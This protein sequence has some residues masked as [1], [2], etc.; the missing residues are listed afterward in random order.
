MV[1]WVCGHNYR[2]PVHKSSVGFGWEVG[3][4]I[5]PNRR[6]VGVLLVLG[7][8]VLSQYQWCRSPSRLVML[9]EGQRLVVGR[10]PSRIRRY[11]S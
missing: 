10:Q 11:S 4:L 2:V 1:C 5:V 6:L 3:R 8:G 9:V 7:Q